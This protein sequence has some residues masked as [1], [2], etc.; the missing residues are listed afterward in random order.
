MNHVIEICFCAF[1]VIL[2]ITLG[3]V[4]LSVCIKIIKEIKKDLER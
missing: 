4:S 1:M 3:L 2:S